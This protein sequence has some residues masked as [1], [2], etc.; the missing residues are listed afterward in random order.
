MAWCLSALFIVFDFLIIAKALGL[1]KTI[2][3]TS[4]GFYASGS[5]PDRRYKWTEVTEF[6]HFTMWASAAPTKMVTFSKLG[7]QPSKLDNVNKSLLGGSE[8]IPAIGMSARALA[9][10][11][12]ERRYRAIAAQSEVMTNLA[13]KQMSM[14]GHDNWAKPKSKPLKQAPRDTAQS[15]APKRRSAPRPQSNTR[16]VQKPR[17][18]FGRKA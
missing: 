17:P 2:I 15:V 12:N 6:G 5:P 10:L 3:L 9:S 1:G 13:L 8:G 16:I 7:G 11:M 14:H 4:E 18:V